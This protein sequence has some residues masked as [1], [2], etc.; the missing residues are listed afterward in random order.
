MRFQRSRA[1]WRS[2]RGE[3]EGP[4]RGTRSAAIEKREEV[5]DEAVMRYHREVSKAKRV[6]VEEKGFRSKP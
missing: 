5:G 4:W 1:Q 3:A 2:R 6:R